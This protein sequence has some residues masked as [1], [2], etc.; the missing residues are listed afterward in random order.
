MAMVIIYNILIAIYKKN[1]KD[2]LQNESIESIEG[3]LK[4]GNTYLEKK[5]FHIID[6]ISH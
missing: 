2:K 5:D 1:N 3:A 4:E 6:I